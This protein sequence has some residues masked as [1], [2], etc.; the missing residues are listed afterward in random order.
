MTTKDTISICGVLIRLIEPDILRYDVPKD[1]KI[2]LAVM[3]ELTTFGTSVLP[4]KKRRVLVVFNSNFI[5]SRDATDFMVS[6][7]RTER[8]AAEAFCI[9]S[10]ALR[11]ITNFYFRIKKPVIKSQAFE[12]ETL[13]LA[14]LRSLESV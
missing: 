1:M 5:P 3:Q 13:A 11:L 14:W 10:P 8:I 6:R 7:E 9:N 2:T 4:D 12:N